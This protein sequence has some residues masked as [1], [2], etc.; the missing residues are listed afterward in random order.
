[1]AGPGGAPPPSDARPSPELTLAPATLAALDAVDVR[2][3]GVGVSSAPG[4]AVDGEPFGTDAE[5]SAG[6]GGRSGRELERWVPDAGVADVGGLED[7]GGGGGGA[8]RGR[9]GSGGSARGNWNQFADNEAKFGVTTSYAEDFYTTRV[10]T[11][12]AGISLAE[13]DRIAREIERGATGTQ[14][15]HLA[16][17]RGA[18]LGD[19]VDEEALYSS[20]QRAPAPGPPKPAAWSAAGSGVAAVAGAQT[21]A[22]ARPAAGRAATSHPVDVVSRDVVKQVRASLAASPYGTPTGAVSPVAAA[23]AAAVAPLDLNP[24]RARVDPAVQRDFKAFKAA[25][26]AK[27]EAAA[28]AARREALKEAGGAKPSAAPVAAASSSTP[29]AHKPAPGLNPNAKEFNFNP[30]AVE[31]KPAGFG[32]APSAAAAAAAAATTAAAVAPPPSPGMGGRGRGGASWQ[33]GRPGSPGGRG[34]GRRGDRGPPQHS[35]HAT[36]LGVPLGAPGWPPGTMVAPGAPY[37]AMMLGSPS[38]GA[39]RGMVLPS[40]Y[41]GPPPG[42]PPGGPYG[43]VLPYGASPYGVLL[44]YPPGAVAYAPM[45]PPPPQPQQHKPRP[46]RRAV[47]PQVVLSAQGATLVPVPVPAPP[48]LA[49]DAA[50]AAGAAAPAGT[51]GDAKE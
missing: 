49:A 31:F 13:A 12:A 37:G 40:P 24:G 34:G 26:S 44:P 39:G 19:D 14:N 10:V 18:E 22:P 50:P 42:G 27:R 48:A 30:G 41:G 11:A 9:G 6:R 38:G 5:I 3:T 33:G 46:P 25:E 15:A 21:S 51:N 29:A 23:A 20:V 45:A 32:A 4:G 1:M 8:G 35:G 47:T 7:G 17:E 2:L 16:E 28:A 43:T 36:Q